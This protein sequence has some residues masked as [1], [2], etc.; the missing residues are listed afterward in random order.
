[1]VLLGFK[2]FLVDIELYLLGFLALLGVIF[3]LI[4]FMYR[5]K[6]TKGIKRRFKASIEFEEV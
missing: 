3:I 6:P 1:M 4:F 5:N 2:D